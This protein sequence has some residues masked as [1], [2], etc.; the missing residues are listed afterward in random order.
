MGIAVQ[1]YT[2]RDF[3]TNAEGFARTLSAISAI[4]YEAVQLSAV[5][6]MNGKNPD[7]GA[8]QARRMLDDCGL[9]CIATHRNW[10]DLAMNTDAEIE[11]HKTLGCS[12][13]AI[14]G[15]PARYGDRGAEG[16][17][18]FIQDAAPVIAALK[19]AGVVFGYHNH[20]HEFQKIESE[21][22][23]TLFDLFIEGGGPDF[24]LEIDVYWVNHAG[25][26]PVR[27]FDRCVGRAPVVHLKD[28]EVV[29][30]EGPVMAP[31]GEGN[32]DWQS[33]L[34][35]CV[36]AGVD[37]YAVEQDVCLRDP[38]DCLRSSFEFLSC[39]GL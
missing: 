7:V 24:M 29:A 34:P 32:M 31:V 37:W 11:F 36:L 21:G 3:T 10:D 18:E 5:G 22:G 8:L 15:I 33:I 30:K 14:G 17:R 1:M 12:F 20:A 19:S 35:A 23:K 25:V 9:K 16:Y 13:A 2:V 6:A 4:G 28:K 27:I 26:N 39:Q 38:F